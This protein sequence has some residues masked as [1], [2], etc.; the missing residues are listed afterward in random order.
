MKTRLGA[1]VTRKVKTNV[2][3]V[4]TQELHKLVIKKFKRRKV[5]RFKVNILA[6]NLAETG[7]F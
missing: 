3:E 2:N 1:I 4:L 5:S 7:S 6:T